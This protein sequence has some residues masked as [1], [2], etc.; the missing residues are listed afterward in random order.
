MESLNEAYQ[1]RLSLLHTYIA[2]FIPRVK[3]TSKPV[4]KNTVSAMD[5]PVTDTKD[6]EFKISDLVVQAKGKDIDVVELLR[7]H[8]SVT[9]VAV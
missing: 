2:P 7:T 6:M 9:E 4:R 3:Q 5:L 8:I 1:Q